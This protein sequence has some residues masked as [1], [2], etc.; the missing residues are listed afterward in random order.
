MAVS[1]AR[2]AVR[3]FLLKGFLSDAEC[4]HMIEL[5]SVRHSISLT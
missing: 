1:L 4:D 5:V 2:A 3:A